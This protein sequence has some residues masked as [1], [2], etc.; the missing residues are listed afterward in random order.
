MTQSRPAGRT[1]SSNFVLGAS[2]PSQ[3]CPPDRPGAF[4]PDAHRKRTSSQ[5]R[6]QANATEI[7]PHCARHK[8]A[9]IAA[10]KLLVDL[11]AVALLDSS[12]CQQYRAGSVSSAGSPAAN[13]QPTRHFCNFPPREET[14]VV[15][16][17]QQCEFVRFDPLRIGS[18]CG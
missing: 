4:A 6:D 17:L 15:K 10:F 12:S 16:L 18:Q 7:S 14:N 2:D 8:G 1:S 9:S 11:A 3:R 13:K 5:K